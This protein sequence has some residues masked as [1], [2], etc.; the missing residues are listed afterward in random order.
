MKNVEK[1][2]DIAKY[3]KPELAETGDKTRAFLNCIDNPLCD[4]VVVDVWAMR[5]VLGDIKAKVRGMNTQEY[6]GYAQ[7]YRCA[8]REVNLRPMQIQAVTWCAV[9]NRSKRHASVNQMSMF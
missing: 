5:V 9:R 4:D 1:A 7:A 6:N 3:G 8:G 2:W